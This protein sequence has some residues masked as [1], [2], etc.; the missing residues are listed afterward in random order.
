VQGCGTS[1]NALE[2]EFCVATDFSGFVAS[3]NETNGWVGGQP[4]NGIHLTS[5]NAGETTSYCRFANPILEGMVGSGNAGILLEGALGNDFIGGTSEG[6]DHG[7][8]TT[9][10]S[11]QNRFFG[12]DLE[13]NNTRDVLEQGQGNEYWGVDSTKLVTISTASVFALFIGGNHQSIELPT[14]VR[15][16]RFCN[17]AVNRTG[18]G[19][20]SIGDAL[21]VCTALFDNCIDLQTQ[22][23]TPVA[24]QKTLAPPAGPT[25]FTYT[26][27]TPNN[28]W[29]TF[30]GG[31][32]TS[33]S[34]TRQGIANSLGLLVGGWPLA[35]GDTFSIAYSG[36]A[37]VMTLYA[38]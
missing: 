36:A 22:K 12:I 9:S 13:A 29:V 30:S 1:S 5:R 19:G 18:G 37:P 10:A 26:N 25:T 14:G 2:V 28:Q 35:P 11:V 20:F 17:V 15:L 32:V 16:P 33:T 8:I 4:K 38:M 24:R 6:C 21:D 3:P 23:I 31:S 27:N 34:I 7:I